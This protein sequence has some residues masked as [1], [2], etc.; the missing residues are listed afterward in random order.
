LE[1]AQLLFEPDADASM[2]DF[3]QAR[4]LYQE[5]EGLDSRV[6]RRYDP[7]FEVPEGTDCA[8]PGVPAMFP[9]YCVGPATLQPNLLDAFNAGITGDAPREQA[10]RIEGALIWFLYVSTAKEGL[11]CATTAKD[12]DS[13]YAYYTGGERARGGIGLARLL[14][15]VDPYAHD[16]AWDGLLALRCWRDIDSAETAGDRELRER[17]REQYD[18][19]L[20][21]GLAAIL[22]DR[23]DELA[24]SAGDAA[25]YH[26]GL[27]KVLGQAV[28]RAARV[29][30]AADADALQAALAA[31]QPSGI[32][33][34]QAQAAIDALFD[35]P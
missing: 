25:R 18:R 30:S 17:A 23:L 9:G 11:T 27:V 32:E 19:A 5:N 1:I 33:V 22:R 20:L 13:A 2:E 4:S 35:C 24:Q 6:V 26:F 29:R 8:L 14:R 7:H 15:E 31:S 28:E 10:G 34:A 3:L 21:D 12:C 16:R